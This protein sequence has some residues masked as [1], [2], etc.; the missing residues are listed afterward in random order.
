M[1]H[2]EKTSQLNNVRKAYGDTTAATYDDSYGDVLSLA[3]DQLVLSLVRKEVL[4]YRR[5]YPLSNRIRF[6]DIGM[7]TGIV[8]EYLDPE[9]YGLDYMGFDLSEGMLHQAQK[10][11]HSDNPKIDPKLTFFQADMHRMPVVDQSVDI[12]VSLYGPVS[13]SL[14]PENF[15]SEVARVT[16]PGSRVFLMPCTARLGAGPEYATGF[17]TAHDDTAT[18]M[19]YGS[20]QIRDMLEQS[21]FEDIEVKGV[22]FTGQLL[23]DVVN[24]AKQRGAGIK[25]ITMAVANI[26]SL[27]KT[28][29]HKNGGSEIAS[30]NDALRDFSRQKKSSPCEEF[31]K[32]YKGPGLRFLQMEQHTLARFLD[33]GL[34]RHMFATATRA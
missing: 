24:S 30:L 31:A 12:A 25:N 17:S 14:Q 6:V 4:N 5:A 27:A 15:F 18:K 32:V 21:G 10:K 2:E 22:N 3:G 23:Q 28:L 11:Q 19:F 26:T 9:E 1:I 34:A 16:H 29:N 8:P 20:G 7:G 33:A 13:Y